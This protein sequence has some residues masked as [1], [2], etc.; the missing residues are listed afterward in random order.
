MWC[1]IHK[2]NISRAIETSRPPEGST[3]RH[4]ESCAS[5]HE[6]DRLSRSLEKRLAADAAALL[7]SAD[8]SLA[9]RVISKVAAAHPAGSIS[10]VP[11][12]PSVFRSRPVWAAAASLAVIVG[13]GFIWMVSTP[14]AKMPRLDPLLKLDGPRAFLE[15]TL[16]KAES[17]YEDEIRGLKQAVTSTA[18][19]L[20][21]R[22]DVG[23]GPEN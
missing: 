9:G 8:A 18:D 23:L 16:Q 21:S 7:D 1:F 2:R 3:R 6:F 12:R 5:C 13:I 17:P 19:Y 14:P 11:S 20:L 10:P 22:L 15:T 4:L